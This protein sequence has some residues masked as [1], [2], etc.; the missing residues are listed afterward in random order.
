MPM[1]STFCFVLV[2]AL[3]ER[4]GT[5]PIDLLAIYPEGT[6]VTIAQYTSSLTPATKYHQRELFGVDSSIAVYSNT[7]PFV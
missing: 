4:T 5:L 3:S 7:E 6:S 1:K 2:I